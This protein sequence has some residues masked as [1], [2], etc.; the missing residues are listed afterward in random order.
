MK[1]IF[2]NEKYLPNWILRLSSRGATSETT[3]SHFKRDSAAL[4][5]ITWLSE[6]LPQKTGT[7]PAKEKITIAKLDK[8]FEESYVKL[9][10]AIRD[11]HNIVLVVKS[12]NGWKWTQGLNVKALSKDV[13]TLREPAMNGS[14]SDNMG[15]QNLKVI[16]QLAN[17]AKNLHQCCFDSQNYSQDSE[18]KARLI[19]VTAWANL[20]N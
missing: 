11:A 6:Q 3:I 18:K 15:R 14:L 20:F 13:S 10:N 19:Y 1:L 4:I 16:I 8:V 9:T 17:L 12:C 7:L 5:G 2:L